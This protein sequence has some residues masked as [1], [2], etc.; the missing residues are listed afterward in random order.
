MKLH[1]P[2]IKLTWKFLIFIGVI[3]VLPLMAMGWASY[4]T[5]LYTMELQAGQYTQELTTQQRKYLDLLLQEIESLMANLAS[6][7]DIK[8]VVAQESP[9]TD[10]YTRLTTNARIGYIL[11]GYTNLRGLVSIDIFTAGG[12]QYH[13]GDT[14]NVQELRADALARIQTAAG[15]ARGGSSGWASTITSIVHR[16]RKRWRWRLGRSM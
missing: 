10:L 15:R 2:R 3:S 12:D 14:L 6:L 11:S 1:Y 5:A 8:Q 9:E 16:Q 7:D 4:Q 13:V